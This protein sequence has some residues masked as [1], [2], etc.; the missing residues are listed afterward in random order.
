[1]VTY[2]QLTSANS[3]PF[4]DAAKAYGDLADKL[5]DRSDDAAKQLRALPEAWEGEGTDAAAT[6]I[7]NAVTETDDA[8]LMLQRCDQILADFAGEL[9][10]AKSMLSDAVADARAIP[11]Q[12]AADGTLTVRPEDG[13]P[14]GH[15][16]WA[17][18]YKLVDAAQTAIRD[19]V[20]YATTADTT[21][22]TDLRATVPG[23]KGKPYPADKIPPRGTDPKK[24]R[25]WWNSLSP[26]ERQYLIA[27]FPDKVGWLDGVPA[28][29][30]DQANRLTLAREQ[31]RIRDE[32]DRLKAEGK[33]GTGE[34]KDLQGKLA[35]LDRI[36]QRLLAA[37]GDGKDADGMQSNDRR[38][39]LLG[40]DTS[41]DGKAI[42]AVG[43]PDTADNIVTYIPGTGADLSKVGGDINRVDRMVFDAQQMDPTKRTAGILWLGYD[44][45]D[46]IIQFPPGGDAT[47]PKYAVNAGNDL[48]LFQDGL[49]VTHD[50]PR[51][52]NTVLGHSYGSTVVGYAA[53]D[54]GLDIDNAVFVGSPGV[55]VEKAGDL[56][57]DPNHVYSTHAKNDPIQYALDPGDL[58]RMQNPLNPDVDLIHGHNPSSA[59]FGGHKFA[60]DP[61]T[62]LMKPEIKTKTYD[63]LGPFGPSVTVPVGFD[64]H[65]S[66]AAHSEYWDDGNASRDNIA[67]IVTGNG[68]TVTGDHRK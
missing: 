43:N 53:K 56:G 42:V 21:A 49:R 12:I 40:V 15:P 23:T 66:G 48:D 41:G 68:G 16:A 19:A 50:G 3:Q 36:E 31:H 9:D 26:E 24:V 59:D 13:P 55:G 18:V 60:S 11:A 29:N 45:P 63:P 62:P 35:G 6:A 1:M 52:T 5:I 8:V 61:G 67:K 7:K 28:E 32:L 57:L 33:E 14:S 58:V 44:A 27:H 20:Q 65:L 64:P 30:R 34:Y 54:H 38:A 4:R 47:D 46:K 17:G 10:K 39:Y 2:A 37:G 25:D 22:T 51:S